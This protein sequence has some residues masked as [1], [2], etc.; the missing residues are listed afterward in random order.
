MEGKKTY[1]V[2]RF[3]SDVRWTQTRECQISAPGKPELAMSS[4]PEFKGTPGLWSPEDMFVAS[5]NVCTLMTFLAYSH[6]KNLALISYE[7]SAEGTLEYSN[8]K[9]RFTEITLHPH[10]MLKSHED[11]EPARAI[12]LD[13]HNNCLITNSIVAQVKIFPDFHVAPPTG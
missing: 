12:L 1:R 5:V 7:C 2:F 10:L 3:E 11:V 4:P 8:G 9:Y 6:H 13:A